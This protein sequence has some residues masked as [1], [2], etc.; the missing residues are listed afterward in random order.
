MTSIQPFHGLKDGFSVPWKKSKPENFKNAMDLLVA[1]GEAFEITELP[2]AM[3]SFS[4]CPESRFF[5]FFYLI[6]L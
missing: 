1:D 2:L 5:T 4:S 6:A 3:V